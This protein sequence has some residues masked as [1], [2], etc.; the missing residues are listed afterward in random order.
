MKSSWDPSGRKEGF[1]F[2]EKHLFK[3][4]DQADVFNN[5]QGIEDN[6]LLRKVSMKTRLTQQSQ[7]RNWMQLPYSVI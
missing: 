4:I 1:G 7:G 5:I 2:R 6:T 3:N